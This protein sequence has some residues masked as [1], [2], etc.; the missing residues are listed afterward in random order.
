M[1]V[2][3]EYLANF[4]ETQDVDDNGELDG[5]EALISTIAKRRKKSEQ[6]IHDEIMNW[7]VNK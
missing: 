7:T 5:V 2:K 1:S 4:P 3:D 6:E